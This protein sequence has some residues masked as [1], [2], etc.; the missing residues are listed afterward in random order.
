MIGQLRAWWRLAGRTVTATAVCLGPA[1]AQVPAPQPSDSLVQPAPGATLPR[2][3]EAT[4]PALPRAERPTLVAKPGDTVD[5]DEVDLPG[6][7]V[8]LIAGQSDWADAYTNLRGAW[9][10]I[11]AELARLGIAPAGRPLALYV[12]T[13]DESFQYEA[14]IPIDAAPAVPPT[15]PSG[16]RFGRSPSGK[17][18]RFLHKGPFNDVETTYETIMSYV[19]AKDIA[20]KDAYL[21]EYVTDVPSDADP[22]LEINIFVQPR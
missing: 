4:R 17:A 6:K 13:S 11:E 22:G 3:P 10:R 5:V 7:P 16:F 12:Q 15:L 1:L 8:L 21:E 20:A 18:Y 9:A 2:P 14:M 19:E